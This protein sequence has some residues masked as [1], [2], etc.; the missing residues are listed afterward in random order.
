MGRGSKTD[1]AATIAAGY[2]PDARTSFESTLYSSTL[3]Q[4]LSRDGSLLKNYRTYH[5]CSLDFGYGSQCVM[6]RNLKYDVRKMFNC[7][8]QSYFSRP[9][10]QTQIR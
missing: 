10:T 6:Y 1:A 5:A 7:H 3:K 2:L 4:F 8:F 9:N